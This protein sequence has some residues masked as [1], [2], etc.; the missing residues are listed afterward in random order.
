[1]YPRDDIE[2]NKR[3]VKTQFFETFILVRIYLEQFA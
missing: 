1:M 3:N 2:N